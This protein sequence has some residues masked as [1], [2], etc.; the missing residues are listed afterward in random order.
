MGGAFAYVLSKSGAKRLFEIAQTEGIAYGI[1]TFV[2]LNSH[3]VQSL[4]VVP[5]FVT[6]PVAR[7][8]GPSVDTDIQYA[9]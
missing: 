3:R 2:L 1:D 4:E 9:D 5:N 6:S 8:G 7:L